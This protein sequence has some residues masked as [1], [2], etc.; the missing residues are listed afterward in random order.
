MT[1]DRPGMDNMTDL[2][3]MHAYSIDGANWTV[4]TD[5]QGMPAL[6]WSKHVKWSNGS[7]TYVS[8]MERPQVRCDLSGMYETRLDSSWRVL[9]P[10]K[11][12]HWSSVTGGDRRDQ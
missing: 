1:T 12:H 9:A 3:G 7:T 2:Y 11:T 10:F 5:T 6:P 8:R 4:A